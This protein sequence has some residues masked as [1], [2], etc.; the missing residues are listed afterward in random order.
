MNFTSRYNL[1]VEF[2]PNHSVVSFHVA[3]TIKA[4]FKPETNHETQSVRNSERFSCRS[5]TADGLY[6]NNEFKIMLYTFNSVRTNF[7]QQL[8]PLSPPNVVFGFRSL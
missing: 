3:L 8:A 2:K 6:I 4:Y 7:R 5:R 1:V